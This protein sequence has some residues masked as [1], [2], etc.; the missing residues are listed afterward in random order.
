MNANGCPVRVQNGYVG[1]TER[2]VKHR[3][4][5]LE[6]YARRPG[7]HVEHVPVH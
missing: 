3:V 5:A 4:A 7:E 1:D 6:R 2:A